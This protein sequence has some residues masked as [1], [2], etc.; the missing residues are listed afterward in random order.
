M[1]VFG[2]TIGK[3]SIVEHFYCFVDAASYCHFLG[4]QSVF[5]RIF[6]PCHLSQGKRF[7]RDLTYP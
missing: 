1:P 7:N 3:K 6:N 2:S 4:F 5:I